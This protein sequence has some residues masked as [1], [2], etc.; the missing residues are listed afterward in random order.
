MRSPS[1]LRYVVALG[2]LALAF[3]ARIALAPLFAGSLPY[4]IVPLAVL[5]AGWYC[6]TGPAVMD[7]IIGYAGLELLSPAPFADPIPG[8][9]VSVALNGTIIFFIARFRSEHNRL[10]QAEEKLRRSEAEI[11]KNER[12]I[13]ATF[14]SAAV[15]ITEID[16]SGRFVS[17]NEQM[18]RMTGYSRQELLRMS[19]CE[20]TAPEDRDAA[21]DLRTMMREGRI[22]RVS[23]DKRYL[24]RDGSSLWGHVTTSPVREATGAYLSSVGT[25]EDISERKRAEHALQESEDRYRDLIKNSR[26]LICTYDLE[27]T[28]LSVSPWAA[29]LL[30]YEVEEL[31]Q[32]NIREFLPGEVS[33][34][35]DEHLASIQTRGIATGLMRLRTRSG[36]QRVWEYTSTLR[37]EGLPA[38]IVRG[39]GHD[40]SERL[41]AER[42]LRRSEEL[43][44]IALSA[45]RAGA[46]AR[47]IKSGLLQWSEE[48]Y[49]MLGLQ[50]GA[51]EPSLDAALERIHA[52]DRPRFQ[53]LIAKAIREGEPIDDI[54]RIVPAPGRVRW[55]RSIS[56]TLRDPE[57][58][59]RRVTGIVIDMT[60]HME[61]NDELRRANERLMQ[62]DRQKDE[63]LAMLS[64]EL[65]NPLMPIKHALYILERTSP[66]SE[67]ARRAKG[68]IERQVDQITRLVNDLLDVSRISRGKIALQRERL[69]LCQVIER[70]LEDHRPLFA[71]RG[72]A[73][74]GC[75]P[76]HPIWVNGDAARLAQV[77]GNLLH[78]AEK[79]S[80]DRGT[81]SIAIEQR[82]GQALM[83]VSDEGAGI[84]PDL[85]VRVFEPFTQGEQN[86]ARTAGG[87]GLGLALVKGLVELHGGSVEA[88]S[89]GKDRGSRFTVRLPA[90]AAPETKC[91]ATPERVET[92][93]R[94]VLVIEDDIDNAETLCEVLRLD[95]HDVA[96]SHSGPD[97]IAKAGSFAPEVVLCDIGLPGMSGYEVARVFRG[98]PQL[99][100]ITLVALTG[101]GSLDDKDRAVAAGFDR[102]LVKPPTHEDLDS[103]LS[104]TSQRHAA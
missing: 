55:V 11:E 44:R 94:R 32:K 72:I 59:P 67:Q 28:L 75:Q 13:R 103:V 30:G 57:G 86:L 50:P 95:G 84:S 39:M 102:H 81:V 38:P 54:H 51:I 66:G 98:N 17:V 15:G 85:L 49:R 63:F 71:L 21:E 23:F 68:T 99:S 2:L 92:Q 78:N 97:G 65:R 73:L 24:R 10:T 19:M 3:V 8:L 12:R 22:D 74:Q 64:H 46:W 4:A 77:L 80:K 36:E 45:A 41:K 87:L 104:G 7:A 82:D 29:R 91:G 1:V 70:T 47:D 43:L 83:H 62:E 34:E 56:R 90:E 33:R 96:V 48:Y 25:I 40:I 69:D 20:I 89:E 100:R 76:G 60:D 101:Y 42:A 6:G 52:E 14:D 27:G 88:A 93:V 37:R 61:T 18:C 35:F 26:V 9:A 53:Q 16:A 58:A 79:F 5:L 31:V